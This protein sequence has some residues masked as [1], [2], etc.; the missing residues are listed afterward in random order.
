MKDAPFQTGQTAAYLAKLREREDVQ[1]EMVTDDILQVLIHIDVREHRVDNSAWL[2]VS[3]IDRAASRVERETGNPFASFVLFFT[4]AW[5]MQNARPPARR[6][7][8][9]SY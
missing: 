7:K 1:L 3:A 4:A 2:F 8:E 6:K 9:A 5:N